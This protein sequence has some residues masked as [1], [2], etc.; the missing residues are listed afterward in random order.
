MPIPEVLAFGMGHACLNLWDFVIF[1][2]GNPF[3]PFAMSP[4]PLVHLSISYFPETT[5]VHWL[6]FG[7]IKGVTH[8]ALDIFRCSW[9]AG[10]ERL[11][12]LGPLC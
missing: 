6:L 1:A 12:R 11:E 7:L 5:G 8:V 10:P 9:D 3:I 4:P 2:D